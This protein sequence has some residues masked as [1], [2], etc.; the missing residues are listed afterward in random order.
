[1][2]KLDCWSFEH[3]GGEGTIKIEQVQTRREDEGPILG[4]LWKHN[5][6]MPR[7]YSEGIVKIFGKSFDMYLSDILVLVLKGLISDQCSKLYRN[8]SIDLHCNV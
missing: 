1:M 7:L 4:V 5:K 8:Q 3:S 2:I 6:W